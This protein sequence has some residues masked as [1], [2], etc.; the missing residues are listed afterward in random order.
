MFVYKA[1]HKLQT[2]KGIKC[3]LSVNFRFNKHGI[4]RF[5]LASCQFSFIL[6]PADWEQETNVSAYKISGQPSLLTVSPF[7]KRKTTSI[8]C[9]LS[10]IPSMTFEKKSKYSKITRTEDEQ[11]LIK[12]AQWNPRLLFNVT[13]VLICSQLRIQFIQSQDTVNRR[14]WKCNVTH[15]IC[16]FHNIVNTPDF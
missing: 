8:T 14:I 1:G 15:M 16:Y 2:L 7:I 3:W 5:V 11:H 9:S 6:F 13:N 4:W 10:I 12:K